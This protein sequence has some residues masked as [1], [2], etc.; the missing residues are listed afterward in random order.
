M[1]N[2][3]L[4]PLQ[5]VYDPETKLQIG[6]SIVQVSEYTFDVAFPFYWVNVNDNVEPYIYYW[7]GITAELTPVIPPPVVNEKTVN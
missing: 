3:L 7:N 2:A 4:S 5:P 6:I 1:L